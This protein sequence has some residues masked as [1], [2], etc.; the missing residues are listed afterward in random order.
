[1]AGGDMVPGRRR[2]TAE[3]VKRIVELRE[4]GLEFREIAAEVG[5]DLKTVW[6]HYQ[7][8]MRQIPAAAI[9][10]HAKK[11]AERLDEQLRRI[12]MERELLEEIVFAHHVQVSNGMV[13][14]P[15]TGRDAAGKPKYGDPITDF[16]PIMRA[17]DRLGKLDDQEAKLLGMYPKQAISVSRETSEVDTAVIALIEQAK[18]RAAERSARIKQDSSGE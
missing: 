12:D 9:E 4:Q 8:A 5:R 2:V 11:C 13:V 1:M 3:T 6:R 16:D 15:I 7:N 18:A 10:E 14:R 17:I